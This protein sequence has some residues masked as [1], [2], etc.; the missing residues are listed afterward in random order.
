M[1]EDLEYRGYDI[2]FVDNSPEG[3]SCQLWGAL[4]KIN[5]TWVEVCE[6]ERSPYDYI[7]RWIDVYERAEKIAHRKANQEPWETI[8]EELM[9]EEE[10][11][12]DERIDP[13][14]KYHNTPE[15]LKPKLEDA[16]LQLSKIIA[17][18]EFII[19]ELGG[20]LE[21]RFFDFTL[22]IERNT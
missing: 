7:D 20:F 17:P 2:R 4:I 1:I 18:I 3:T 13:Y 19:D 15:H 10:R 5:D 21:I 11:E 16:I 8:L 6:T 22:T 9:K 12:D 14:L